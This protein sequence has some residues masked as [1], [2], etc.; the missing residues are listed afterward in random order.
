MFT[1]ALCITAKKWKPPKY[2][3]SDERREKMWIINAME[4]Y[5]AIKRKESQIHATIWMNLED[6]IL[7]EI[8]RHKMT[9]IV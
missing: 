4:H 6:I 2:P 1:E 5:L 8:T 3:S 7:S 9:N